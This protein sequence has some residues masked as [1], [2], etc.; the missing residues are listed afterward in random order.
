MKRTVIATAI[1][2][3][4]AAPAFAQDQ[5]EAL[6]TAI[7]IYNESVDTNAE[8]IN[9]VQL[10]TQVKIGENSAL[11]TAVEIANSSADTPS[12]RISTDTVTVFPS[13]P[14]YAADTIARIRAEADN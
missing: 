1:A 12:D 6:S 14:A 13:E 9:N 3:A 2:A 11:A 10:G 8:R 7:E 5:S 4:V